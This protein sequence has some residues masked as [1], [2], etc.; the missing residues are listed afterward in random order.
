LIPRQQEAPPIH[1]TVVMLEDKANT[2]IEH[3]FLAIALVICIMILYKI[4]LQA[5]KISQ[6]LGQIGI[7]I[8]TRI[9][10]L[11]LAAIATQFIIGGLDEI[12]LV[13][14]F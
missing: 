14:L 8:M 2:F 10:G 11:I 9:M 12:T 5:E 7:N 13:K 4:L 1:T 6:Y 3:L